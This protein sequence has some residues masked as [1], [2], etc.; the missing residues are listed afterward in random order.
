[1]AA[2]LETIEAQLTSGLEAIATRLDKVNGRLDEQGHEIAQHCTE[3]A[4]HGQR[5]ESAEA[6]ATESRSAWRTLSVQV[7]GAVILYF[8]FQVMPKLMTLAAKAAR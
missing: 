1:M 3:L 6:A 7:A 4:L 2:S 5:I 8:L